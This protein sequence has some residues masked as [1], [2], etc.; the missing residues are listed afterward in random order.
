MQR[1]EWAPAD[2]V[3]PQAELIRAI[4]DL[5]EERAVALIRERLAAGTDPLYLMDGCQEGM[6]RVGRRYE[7]E[8]IYLSGLIMGGEIF[9]QAMELVQP[10]IQRQVSGKASG[11]IL[12]GTVQGDIHDLGK[13]IV[14]MLLGCH[15]FTV[16]DLGIDVSPESFAE[17]A[18]QIQ[19]NLVGL[20]GLLTSSY[21][22]M[23]ETILRLREAGCQAPV[24]IGGGQLNEQVFHYIGADHWTTD[25]VAGVELC[26]QLVG[27]RSGS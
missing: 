7:R 14:H 8:E 16:F 18:C 12:L 21:D 15:A 1:D 22:S 6:R 9:R 23:R 17:Q 2:D 24:I 19:P 20:S 26:R 4:S 25:A 27:E 10:A 13:N 5:D 3:A 11:T